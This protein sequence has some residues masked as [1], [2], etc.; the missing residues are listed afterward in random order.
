MLNNFLLKGK[1]TRIIFMYLEYHTEEKLLFRIR[2]IY[3]AY[4]FRRKIK[5]KIALVMPSLLA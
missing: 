5:R 4:I 2:L 1:I 3:S